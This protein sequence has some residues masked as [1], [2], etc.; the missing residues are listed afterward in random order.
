MTKVL[1]A[2]DKLRIDSEFERVEFLDSSG[3]TF[4]NAL[5]S[6]NAGSRFPKMSK[7]KSVI[8]SGVALAGEGKVN[9]RQ[10]FI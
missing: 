8:Y 6:M 5:A 7:D 9:F 1:S 2:N 10:R 3:G 4:T